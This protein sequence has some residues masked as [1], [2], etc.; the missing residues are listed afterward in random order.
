MT[1]PT[2][3][4]PQG[5]LSAAQQIHVMAGKAENEKVAMVLTGLSVLMLTIMLAKEAGLLPM[6]NWQDREANRRHEGHRGR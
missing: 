6:N 4:M 3:H 5:P 2:S 1:T